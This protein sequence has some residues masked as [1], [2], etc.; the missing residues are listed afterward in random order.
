MLVCTFWDLDESLCFILYILTN[1]LS[2][3]ACL[4]GTVESIFG[5]SNAVETLIEHDG[6]ATI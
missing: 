3:E 2:G 6:G 4:L 1:F 5:E